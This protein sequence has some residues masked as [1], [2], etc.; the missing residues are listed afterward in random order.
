[1]SNFICKSEQ[2]KIKREFESEFSK[3]KSSA[4][5]I[6]KALATKHKRSVSTIHKITTSGYKLEAAKIDNNIIV[7]QIKPRLG[8]VNKSVK[9]LIFTSWEIRVG[10]DDKFVE[11]LQNMKNHYNAELYF[12]P[13][14]P[15]DLKFISPELRNKFTILDHDLSINSN[16]MFKYVPTHALCNSPVQGWEGAHEK[17]IIIPGLLKD[18]KTEKSIRLCKQIISTGSIGKLNAYLG[19]YKHVK[20]S[21]DKVKLT[22]RWSMV[23]NRRGGRAYEVARQYI[24]PTALIVDVVDDKTF[25][26]RYVTMQK[27]GVVYDKNL[28]FT[29]ENKTPTISQP[30]V[31]VSGDFHE[32]YTD[33]DN[34]TALEDICST[35]NPKS[36]VLNDFVD[37]QS[38][39]DH[40]FDDFAH[41]S[42]FP[43][44]QEEGDSAKKRLEII[45]KWASKIYYLQSNH[46]NRLVRFLAN[47]KLYKLIGN[48]YRTAIALRDWQLKTNKHPV[49]KLLGLDNIKNLTFVPEEQVLNINGVFITHG[50]VGISGRPS[51][52]RNLQKIYNHYVQGHTHVP[53]VFRN[54]VCVGTSSKLNLGYNKGPSGWM[55]AHALIQ[56][57]GTIQL[58]P[59]I[60]GKWKL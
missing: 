29:S 54:G 38:V 13:V 36:L 35:L 56:P 3:G 60:Y 26:T 1:M 24:V 4:T 57:D 25:F 49:I 55:H 27:K 50:H 41:V 19:N 21:D 33:E 16:L 59:V 46:D 7:K 6:R 11:I 47:E 53:E 22:K 45:S 52:F 20:D 31:L 10:V 2:L 18:I 43:S 40:E 12:S 58:L 42:N 48:N 51:T 34:F 23:Q 32:F 8:H 9:T 44:I 15:D 28:K 17:T 39:N 37:F 14:W 30:E 5:A